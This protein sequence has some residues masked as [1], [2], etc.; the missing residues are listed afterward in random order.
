MSMKKVNKPAVLLLLIA[1][2]AVALFAWYEESIENDDDDARAATANGAKPRGA[3]PLKMVADVE[4]PGPTN[5]F[6]YLSY[7]PG[8]HLLFIAH[9][10][11]GTVV[12]FDAESSK[13]VAEIPGVSEV[14]GVL[15]VPDLHKVYASATGTNEVAVIDE[16]TLKVMARIPGGVY[17]DGMAY[18]PDAHK[19]YV[20]D[21]SGKTETVI[22]VLT[23][24]R[25]KTILL[26]GEAGNSQYDPVS[27]HVFVNVQTLGELA[28]ID[29]AS[30]TVIA[31]HALTGAGRNHGLL[32]EPLQRLAFIACEDNAKLL[33]FDMKSKKV[34]QTITVGAD[35]DVLAF[36]DALGLL[37]V[38]S[39]SGVV[40]V[41][42]EQGQA[43]SRIGEALLAQKA[44]SVAVDQQTHRVYFPLQNLN[45]RAMLRIMEPVAKN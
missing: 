1:A 34:I 31:R 35:P 5:R 14:H 9:L 3:L 22:D 44:H 21:Q 20:S 37:Y 26:N 16:K 29:P 45:G 25:I 30:D 39:E 38:A 36:D 10:A 7:D 17:P 32:I 23:D 8:T 4:L 24:K 15:V 33:V 13:V 12:V 19:L 40:S 11:A 18:A 28:E 6:D 42:H 43:L 2:F 41:F 27:K